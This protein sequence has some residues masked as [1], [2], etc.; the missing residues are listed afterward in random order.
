[1]VGGDQRGVGL[2][3]QRAIGDPALG[4]HI[5]MNLLTRRGYRVR[6]N[7]KQPLMECGIPHGSGLLGKF[8]L[9][10]PQQAV[11]E[12]NSCGQKFLGR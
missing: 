5:Q 9:H 11:G 2:A 10:L 3:V 6:L 1:M 4:P 8:G 7:H 12:R